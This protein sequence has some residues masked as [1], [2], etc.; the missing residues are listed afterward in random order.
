MRR[1]LVLALVLSAAGAHAACPSGDYAGCKAGCEKGDGE[2]CASLGGMYRTGGRGVARDEARA[3][4]LFRMA[5]DL[6]SVNGCTSFRE[7][8]REGRGVKGR[9]SE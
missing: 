3:A 8:Y 5:C 7:M 9:A 1:W 2:A 6:G 4:E